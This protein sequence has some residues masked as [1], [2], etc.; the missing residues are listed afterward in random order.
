M[1][2]GVS[3][4]EKEYYHETIFQLNELLRYLLVDSNDIKKNKIGYWIK[5]WEQIEDVNK[6]V[7]T[8]I[9]RT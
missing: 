8:E 9:Y 5:R 2:K 3:N 4:M 1:R 6:D 7:L